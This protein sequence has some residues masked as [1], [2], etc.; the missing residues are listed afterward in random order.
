MNVEIGT[1]VVQFP[2]KEYINGIFL[3]CL[4]SNMGKVGSQENTTGKNSSI[5][6]RGV[7]K[8]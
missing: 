4:I 8:I 3:Q 1:E 2:G 6:I 5:G 7:Y